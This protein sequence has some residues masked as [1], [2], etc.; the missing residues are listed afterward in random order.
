VGREANA[1]EE[2]E[3]RAVGAV[4]REEVVEVWNINVLVVEEN[5][6]L[7]GGFIVGHGFRWIFWS[8]GF[9]DRSVLRPRRVHDDFRFTQLHENRG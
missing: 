2:G 8:S 5:A 7:D 9:M 3:G 4:E 1:A 6:V